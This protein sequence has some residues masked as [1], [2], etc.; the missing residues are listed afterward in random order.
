MA[1]G[2]GSSEIF[3]ALCFSFCLEN[4]SDIPM[5]ECSHLKYYFLIL[6]LNNLKPVILDLDDTRDRHCSYVWILAMEIVLKVKRELL[7]DNYPLLLC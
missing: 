2:K 5:F 7:K 4:I 6:F 3:T 1:F